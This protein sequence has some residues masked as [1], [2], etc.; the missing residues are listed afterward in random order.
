V[1]R[2]KIVPMIGGPTIHLSIT[3][4]ANAPMV[5]NRNQ[6]QNSERQALSEKFA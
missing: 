4:L 3:P 2:K 6:Y 1:A 5:A